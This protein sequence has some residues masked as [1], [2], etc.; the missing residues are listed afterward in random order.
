MVE[1]SLAMAELL[2][3]QDSQ[4]EGHCHV[5]F[6]RLSLSTVHMPLAL[7]CLSVYMQTL[8]EVAYKV[9]EVLQ[10]NVFKM[11]SDR[12]LKLC[13]KSEII[14]CQKYFK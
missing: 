8:V 2:L 4:V 12:H 14:S 1:I 3:V 7:Q 6:H 9:S 10:R 5:A 13:W 11:A